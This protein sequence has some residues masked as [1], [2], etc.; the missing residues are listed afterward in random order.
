[1]WKI[2]SI[3]YHNMI[4]PKFT[5]VLCLFA[6]VS[7]SF[8]SFDSGMSISFISCKKKKY[9]INNITLPLCS[10]GSYSL[11]IKLIQYFPNIIQLLIY[12]L[13]SLMVEII[14]VS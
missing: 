7:R 12:L 1:M 6:N 3:I 11:V 4:N 13:K 14:M 5:S 10:N 9:F 8:E 2:I